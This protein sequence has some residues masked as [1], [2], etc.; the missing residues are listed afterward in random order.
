MVRSNELKS[1]FD[2][3]MQIKIYRLG[4]AFAGIMG[5]QGSDGDTLTSLKRSTIALTRLYHESNPR[6]EETLL[7][8]DKIEGYINALQ[9]TNSISLAKAN[10]LIRDL[11]KLDQE[12]SQ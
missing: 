4:G 11:H 7:L 1:F 2:K 3:I 9:L 6:R 5:S 8:S 12:D 10:E